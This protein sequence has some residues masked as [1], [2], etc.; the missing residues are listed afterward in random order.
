VA[1]RTDSETDFCSHF[2]HE[3]QNIKRHEMVPDVI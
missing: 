3:L 2:A 1:I